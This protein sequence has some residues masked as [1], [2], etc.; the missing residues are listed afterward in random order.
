MKGIA[1]LPIPFLFCTLENF[2]IIPPNIIG[3]K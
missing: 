3:Y 1:I 2:I